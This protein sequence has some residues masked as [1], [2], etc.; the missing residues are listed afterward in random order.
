[1]RGIGITAVDVF[2][3]AL[4]ASERGERGQDSGKQRDQEDK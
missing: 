2:Q 4:I 3:F 1:L